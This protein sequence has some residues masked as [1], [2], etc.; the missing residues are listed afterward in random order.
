MLN[1]VKSE[2][3]KGFSQTKM[4][5]FLIVLAGAPFVGA[6]GSII[7]KNTPGI[8]SDPALVAQLSFT[9]LKYP[10]SVLGGVVDLLVPIFI[11]ILISDMITEEYIKGT[12][13]LALITPNKRERILLSKIATIAIEIGLM[14]GILLVS[15]YLAGLIFFD[16]TSTLEYG[17]ISL[18]VLEGIGYTLGAYALT[19]FVLVAFAV[20]IMFMALHLKSTGS[21][22]GVS[23]G[24]IIVAPLLSLIGDAIGKAI[25]INYFKFY[26]ILFTSFDVMEL[27]RGIGIVLVYGLGSFILSYLT[28]KKKDLVY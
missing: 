28:F 7:L 25:I 1:G 27:L 22:I 8:S 23:V 12:L 16:K 26:N 18:G 4:Y 19:F 5:I 10:L 24:L 6:I 3:I 21:V 11:I 20:L 9:M 14:L 15:S 2:L 17:T 13:K